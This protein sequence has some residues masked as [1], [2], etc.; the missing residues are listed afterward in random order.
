LRERPDVALLRRLDEPPDLAVERFVERF[1]EREPLDREL[2]PAR[3]L[4][5]REPLERALVVREPLER[6]L[7]LDRA[8]ADRAFV[9]RDDDERPFDERDDRPP[10][11]PDAERPFDE[12][13][14][15][16]REL[17]PPRR[18]TAGISSC[19]TAFVSCGMSRPRKS[20]MRSSSRR[21]RFA[22]CAVSLSPT[23]VASASIEV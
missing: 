8:L 16:R 11:E 5:V 22:S 12:R 15:L 23:S 19:A 7:L 21:I 4:V 9:D 10:A 3:A 17:R 6:D 13:D 1:A 18:S 14:A 20:R 2:E